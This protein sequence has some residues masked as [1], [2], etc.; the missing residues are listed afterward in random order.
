MV[1]MFGLIV[2]DRST[3]ERRFTGPGSGFGLGVRPAHPIVIE[4]LPHGRMSG[5]EPG[6]VSDSGGHPVHVPGTLQLPLQGSRREQ[7]LT[8]EGQLRRFHEIT[9]PQDQK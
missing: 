9:D 1:V 4:Q 2:A 6:G 7:S 5:D 3:E 8:R